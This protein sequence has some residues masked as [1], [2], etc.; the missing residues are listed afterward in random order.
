MTEQQPLLK[1]QELQIVFPAPGQ[2]V[3]A[4]NTVSFDLKANSKVA[5][6]GESG[7]GKSVLSLAIFRLL[8]PGTLVQ[9]KIF[10]A[11][12][13]LLR[14]SDKAMAGLRGQDLVLIPQNPLDCLNPVLS[15]GYQVDEAVRRCGLAEKK[16]RK[17]RVLELLEKV[18]LPVPSTLI[19]RYP[20][21]LSGGMAQRV[22]LAI[23]LAGNPRLVVADE[24][25]RGLDMAL[26]DKYLDLITSLYR[27]C[28]LLL[29]T[30]DLDVAARCD[31]VM[32]MYAGEIV[33]AGPQAS[34]LN[35]PQHP[36]TAGL[37][38]AHPDQGMTPIPG[39]SPSLTEELRGCRFH[40]RCSLAQ[41]ICQQEHPEL[42]RKN[43]TMVRCFC[44]GRGESDQKI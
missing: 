24:P 42:I 1:V 23:G 5:I 17:A 14:L 2:P 22:L 37:L 3:K 4:L 31:E 13:D 25:T 27:D 43:Q 35:T 8:P 32:V 21:E 18:G 30:H 20:H 39:L 11:G 41:A 36:Y 26:R 40:P 34:I 9:G 38:A 10:Y 44:A 12:T 6:L 16:L 28:A 29:I 33:E 19:H 7:S 15:I